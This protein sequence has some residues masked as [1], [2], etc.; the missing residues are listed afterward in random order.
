MPQKLLFKA[1]GANSGETKGKVKIV[2]GAEDNGKFK[3]GEILVT[4]MTNPTM[5]MMMARAAAIIT[6]TGGIT[7]HAAITAREMGVPCVVAT[8]TATKDLKDGQE[9][10]VNG[11]KGEVYLIE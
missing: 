1:L 9:V 11:S 2:R 10:L 6:D 5:V 3:D 7:C 8:R 4:V